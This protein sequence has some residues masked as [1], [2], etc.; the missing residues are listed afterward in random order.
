MVT[1]M[2]SRENVMT[3]LNW[4]IGGCIFYS[5]LEIVATE[6]SFLYSFTFT[7]EEDALAFKLKFGL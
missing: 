7:D 3:A 4:A 5:R 1:V 6:E 2:V